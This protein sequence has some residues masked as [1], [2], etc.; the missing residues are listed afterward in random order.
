MIKVNF[1]N[2]MI[3]YLFSYYSKCY[4]K[5]VSWTTLMEKFHR[6]TVANRQIIVLNEKSQPIGPSRAVT[7]ELSRFLGT[8]AKDPA[9]VPFNVLDWKFMPTTDNIWSYVKV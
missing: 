8:L 5:E 3:Y 6:R 7:I 2:L 1:I 9:L 4:K